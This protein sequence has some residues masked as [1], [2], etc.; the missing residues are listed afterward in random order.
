MDHVT[1]YP[2]FNI[3]HSPR[4]PSQALDGDT[5]YSFQRVSV[6]PE[7]TEWSQDKTPFWATG[8]TALQDTGR[9]RASRPLHAFSQ[10]WSPGY[11]EELEGGYDARDASSRQLWGLEQERRAVIQ[12]QAVKKSR[13][14]AT[15]WG[16]P[17]QS[18]GA[19]EYAPTQP[20]E[21]SGV[22]REQI[23]F[24]TARQQFLSLERASTEPPQKPP[25]RDA[26]GGLPSVVS[27]APKALGGP[28]LANGFDISLGSPVKKVG[29]GPKVQG[30]PAGSQVLPAD[31]PR[32][33]PRAPSPDTTRE[34]PIER[35]I[36]LAQ[37]REA[38][39]RAQRGL[40]PAAG[41]QEMVQVPSRPLLTRVTLSPGPRR[42]RG[43]PSLYVQRDIA[44]ETQREHDHRLQGG[45]GGT[46]DWGSEDPLPVLRRAFSSDSILDLVPDARAADPIPE[47]RAVSR[48]PPHVYRPYLGPESPRLQTPPA[49]EVQAA[50]SP[51][52]TVSPRPVSEPSRKALGPKPEQPLPARGGVVRREYFLL[53]PLRFGVPEAPRPA[54]GPPVWGWG[55]PGAPVLRLQ[56]SRS[57][58]LLEREVESVLRRERELAEERRSALFPEIFSPSPVDSDPDSRSSSRASGITGS[59][60]VSESPFFTPIQLH[61]GLVWAVGTEPETPEDPPQD[62]P[63]QRKKKEMWYAGIDPSDRINS[64]VLEATRVTRHKNLMAER[65]EARVYTSEDED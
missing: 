33:L 34:T 37:E 36:R 41:Q 23:D 65:W 35:E 64:E 43:R 9:A 57:S 6:G 24:L 49:P 42:D 2:I 32:P 62:A 5:I 52:A 50:A 29:A 19:L 28:A 10:E 63:W 58:E 54:K 17:S 25:P 56:K 60:S 39:L 44:Q 47:V 46:P 53:R 14:V 40:Q 18:D 51:K 61:S 4:L 8:H 38:A 45:R 22:D 55:A 26:S 3:P 59:Y 48:I 7:E 11:Q 15:L 13:T 20:M 30:P 31:K 21:D 27:Q 12:D 1:R 16:D